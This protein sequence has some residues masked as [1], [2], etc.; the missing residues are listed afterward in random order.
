GEA[1]SGAAGAVHTQPDA[2]VPPEV[3]QPEG[4]AAVQENTVFGGKQFDE[5]LVSESSLLRRARSRM[6]TFLVFFWL[7][8]NAWS[9]FE[10]I[11]DWYVD[12]GHGMA[13]QL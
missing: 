7:N 10:G 12:S 11:H 4:V 9:S 13:K 3:D 8:A 2:A 5:L 6:G 1:A